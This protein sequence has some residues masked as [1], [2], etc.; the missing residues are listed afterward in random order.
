MLGK[1]GMAVRLQQF[2]LKS[3]RIQSLPKDLPY[4]EGTALPVPMVI[5]QFATHFLELKTT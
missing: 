3:Y 1:T 4:L 5:S 2:V